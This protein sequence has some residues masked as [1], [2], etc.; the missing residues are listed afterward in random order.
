MQKRFILLA[1]VPLALGAVVAGS[2]ACGNGNSGSPGGT[3]DAHEEFIENNDVNLDVPPL[4]DAS[5]YVCW[6]PNSGD[7][8]QGVSDPVLLCTQDQVLGFVLQY[9]YV[10]GTGVMSSWSSVPPT[11]TAGTTHDWRDDLGLAAAIGDFHCSATYYGSTVNIAKYDATLVD[12]RTILASELPNAMKSYDGALYYR[13]RSA[14][15]AFTYVSDG[16]DRAA[17]ASAADAWAANVVTSFTTMVTPPASGGTDAGPSDGSAPPGPVALIGMPNGNGTVTY[18]PAQSIMAAAALLDMARV[19]ANDPD[20]GSAPAAWTATAQGTL[21][22][23]WNRG[24]DPVTGLFYQK[25]VTSQDPGHDALAPGGIPTIDAIL[26][27]V[28]G[29]AVLG[30]SR[31]MRALGASV[32]PDGGSQPS[33]PYARWA[34]Q[35]VGSMTA[36]ALFTGQYP[37]PLCQ[38]CG[39]GVE[40]IPQYAG[41]FLEGYLPSLGA[42][43]PNLT[44]AG[45]AYLFGGFALTTALDPNVVPGCTFDPNLN[46]KSCN[47]ENLGIRSALD[48]YTQDPSSSTIPAQHTTFLTVVTDQNGN[49]IQQAYLP[50]V[51]KDWGYARAFSPDGGG[52]GGDAG[53]QPAAGDYGTAA[54]LAMIEGLTQLWLVRPNAPACAY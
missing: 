2:G 39:Q 37:P 10:K 35:I 49:V 4:P 3:P 36:L 15:L 24:R 43:V 17:L 44:V 1:S 51:S 46:L 13:M 12:L 18:E 54:N 14:S 19:H 8:T 6:I 22:Y 42:P 30:L 33:Q 20:A 21:D 40:P 29:P 9:A 47:Y 5:G 32:I 45:N 38:M 41:A 26:T 28:Q 53:L 52:A 23:V 25:L 11:Y 48:E 34:N 16:M 31:A 27:D 50:A 7:K